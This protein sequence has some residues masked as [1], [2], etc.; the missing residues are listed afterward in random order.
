MSTNRAKQGRS[1]EHQQTTTKTRQKTWT[2]HNKDVQ[3]NTNIAQQGDNTK[4]WAKK[5][6]KITMINQNWKQ[7]LKH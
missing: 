7:T 4:L 1:D 6:H 3:T 2:E 5:E